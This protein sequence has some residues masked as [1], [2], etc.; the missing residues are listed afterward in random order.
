MSNENAMTPL[1]KYL[2]DEFCKLWRVLKAADAELQAYK[3]ALKAILSGDILS[4][5]DLESYLTRQRES[6]DLQ[7]KIR[8]KYGPVLRHI[9]SG[10]PERAPNTDSM[11][12]ALE[13]LE[14]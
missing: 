10:L 8:E 3:D 12:Q 5:G 9:L 2:A 1:E 4:A 13:A 7:K 6:P 14:D 11:I